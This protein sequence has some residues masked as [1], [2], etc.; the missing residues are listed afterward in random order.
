M[1]ATYKFT[2]EFTGYAGYSE[3]NRAPTPLELGCA[4]PLH[5]CTID[6]FLVSDPPLKQVVARTV[7]AGIR[8]T[9]DLGPDIGQLGWT[10]GG[11]RTESANDI[12]NVPSQVQGFGYFR[13]VGTTLRQGLEVEANLRSDQV[14]AYVNYALV[15]AT[16]RSPILLSSPNNPFADADGN[17]QVHKGDQ[18][19]LVPRNRVKAGVDYK[20]TS[21][22]TIGGDILYTGSQHLV[23]D[24]ANL[25]GKLPAY[26]TVDVHSS[27]QLTKN[28]QIYGRIE[29]VFDNH[30]YNYGTFFETNAI[31]FANF[32]DPRSVSPGLP[33]AFYAGM[34]ATF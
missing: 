25:T 34:K 2:P 4:D 19:P 31:Q 7:E 27:Y 28:L 10:V 17:I 14:F 18:I 30:Y 32:S 6:N 13:N 1:G 21:A 33:R 12:L 3:A 16:F 5:P 24:E 8:G 26:V 23:G 11:F 9:H 15:D 20:I 29:N 22:F